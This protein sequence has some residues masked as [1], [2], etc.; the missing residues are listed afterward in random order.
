MTGPVSPEASVPPPGRFKAPAWPHARTFE[1]EY[2]HLDVL[3]HLNHAVYFGF[4]ETLRCEYYM[5]LRGTSDPQDLDI[6]ILEATCRY[7]RP[8]GYAETLWGEVA[9]ARPLGHTSF[10]LVYRFSRAQTR[11][12]VAAGRTVVVS[13]DY[14]SASKKPIPPSVREQLERDLVESPPEFADSGRSGAPLPPR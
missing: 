6:I 4:M 7:L 11:E 8:V 1:V 13:F 12:T 2:R 14:A 3:N 10:T 9:P 5:R